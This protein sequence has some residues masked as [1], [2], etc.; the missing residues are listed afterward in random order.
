MEL[1]DS[2]SVRG[3][4]T[5]EELDVTSLSDRG[6]SR[7][8]P[9]T[10]TTKSWPTLSPSAVLIFFRRGFLQEKWPVGNNPQLG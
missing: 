10:L 7:N 9:L 2:M 1:Y 3:H 8:P 4:E 5:K 6:Q